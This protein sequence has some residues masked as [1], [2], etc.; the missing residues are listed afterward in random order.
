MRLLVLP[1]GKSASDGPFPLVTIVHG[2]PYDRY[3]D[4]LQKHFFNG[5]L[6]Y[7]DPANPLWDPSHPERNVPAAYYM[8][9][10]NEI[11]SAIVD[12]SARWG[13]YFLTNNYTRNIHWLREL[14][15]LLGYTNNVGNTA[16]YF[17]NRSANAAGHLQASAGR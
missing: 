1:V 5:G 3:A 17:P 16:N 9:R 12:E 13:G 8:K 10:I 6:F 11:D 7:T 2:G 14:N 4:R 15:N